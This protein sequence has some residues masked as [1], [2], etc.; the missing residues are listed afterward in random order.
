[1]KFELRAAYNPEGYRYFTRLPNGKCEYHTIL[2]KDIKSVHVYQETSEYEYPDGE[3]CQ[4]SKWYV[5]INTIK[6]LIALEEETHNSLIIDNG[7]IVIYDD[8]VE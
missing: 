2:F 8:Y 6:E 4:L 7:E 5:D 1:M 3:K